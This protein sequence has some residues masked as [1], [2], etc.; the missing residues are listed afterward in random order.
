MGN[1]EGF[2][3]FQFDLASLRIKDGGLGILNPTDV[4]KYAYVASFEA[5]RGL[6]KKILNDNPSLLDTI[7][8]APM[9]GDFQRTA[10]DLLQY[11]GEEGLHRDLP[12]FTQH[13]WA[14]LYYEVKKSKLWSSP[15]I[16]S[17]PLPIQRRFMAILKSISTAN[18]SA[19]LYAIPNRG[20]GQVMTLEEFRANMGLRLLIPIFSG[21][22]TCSRPTCTQPM[23]PF[24]YHAINLSTV[25][26]LNGFKDM[27]RSL[28]SYVRS[29]M[30]LVC[31]RFVT[32][33]FIVWA[34]RGALIVPK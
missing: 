24:G 22:K 31:N 16:S 20:L 14:A 21:L 27:R 9:E 3:E 2:G 29:L 32:P 7:N 4:G 33:R 12:Q 17:Q 34:P 6:Q 18:A 19:Y 8:L 11:L 26:P 1:R 5:T 13:Q 15:Y 10:E 23:D 25:A 30:M 28:N